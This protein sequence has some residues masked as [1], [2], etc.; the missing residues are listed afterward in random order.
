M[1]RLRLDQLL[2]PARAPRQSR[3]GQA[4][5]H[6]RRGTGGRPEGRQAGHAG[7]GRRRAAAAARSRALRVARRTQAGGGP[8]LTSVLR[9][10][11]PPAC[12]ASTSAPPPAGSPTACCSA[13]PSTWW[14]RRGHE[15]AGV[16]DPQRSAGEVDRADQRPPPGARRPAGPVR[17][18]HSRPLLH[19]PDQGRATFASVSPRGQPPPAPRQAAIRG[20]TRAGGQGRHRPRRVGPSARRRRASPGSGEPR[21]ACGFGALRDSKIS[22]SAPSAPSTRRSTAARAT[23]KPSHCSA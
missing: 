17:P 8:R 14:P 23:A 19:L 20:R 16:L 21:T 6:G 1:A 12:A 15:P 5:G 22:G 3:E 18:R 13:A 10:S 4:G 11:I 7:E 2:H 9:T